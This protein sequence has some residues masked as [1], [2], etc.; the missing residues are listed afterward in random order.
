MK[1]RKSGFFVDVCDILTNSKEPRRYW[2]DLK[3]KL[4]KEGNE[5]Y[6]K[7]V[8]LK[9]P[10]QDGKM[11]LTDVA[12]TEQLLRII[13]SIPSPK[14]EP[15]KLW[16]AKIGNDRIEEMSDP[17]LAI[18]RALL[19]YKNKGYSDAWINQRNNPSL[20]RYDHWAI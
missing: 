8:Q 19:Y 17:E 4:K 11:R 13:Q 3:I 10:A 20:D 9:M 18:D 5:T 14:A 12:T 2:S 1:T 7:I 6:D 15:F 16:L